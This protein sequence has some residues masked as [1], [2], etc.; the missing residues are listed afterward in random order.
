MIIGAS[1][2]VLGVISLFNIF[3]GNSFI[4]YSVD[5]SV[6]TSLTVNGTTSDLVYESSDVVFSID[7]ITGAIVILIVIVTI[8]SVIGIQILGSGLSDAS[9]RVI[10]AVLVYSGLWGV[11]SVL[12]GSL[13]FSIEVFG[14]VIYIVLTLFYVIGVV[15]KVTE[16]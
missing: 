6:D 2:F 16:G 4:D 9:V 5:N 10:T 13:I 15:E 1:L 8:A 14:S 3:L 7:G 12:S 11:L